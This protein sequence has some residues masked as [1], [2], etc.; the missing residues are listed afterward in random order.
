VRPS[1]MTRV[2]SFVCLFFTVFL[3]NLESTCTLL[4]RDID[5]CNR[6]ASV[7]IIYY[8]GKQAIVVHFPNNNYVIPWLV[9]NYY[10]FYFPRSINDR[11]RLLANISFKKCIHVSGITCLLI[12]CMLSW[13]EFPQLHWKRNLETCSLLIVSMSTVIHSRSNYLLTFENKINVIETSDD[14]WPKQHLIKI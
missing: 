14:N 7:L 2:C 12:Q 10:L 1:F 8:K 9:A 4:F 5:M 6:L 13:Q 3:G 11:R